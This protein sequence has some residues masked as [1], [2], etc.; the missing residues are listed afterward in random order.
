MSKTLAEIMVLP[1]KELF[2]F[3]REA[4]VKARQN[5]TED[6]LRLLA[7]ET[8][9]ATQQAT[10]AIEASTTPLVELPSGED[11]EEEPPQEGAPEQGPPSSGTHRKAAKFSVLF[12]EPPSARKKQKLGKGKVLPAMVPAREIEEESV[13]MHEF[14]EFRTET[15]SRLDMI[16]SILQPGQGF[17][18]V[19]ISTPLAANSSPRTSSPAS[20]PPIRLAPA[21]WLSP[22]SAHASGFGGALAHSPS[23]VLVHQELFPTGGTP[24]LSLPQPALSR[25]SGLPCSPAS[26]F[27]SQVPEFSQQGM[28]ALGSGSAPQGAVPAKTATLEGAQA[29]FSPAPTAKYQLIHV[30]KSCWTARLARSIKKDHNSKRIKE[31]KDASYSLPDDPYESC[32]GFVADWLMAVD[33]LPADAIQARIVKN[34]FLST[35]M[36]AAT[37]ADWDHVVLYIL[38]VRADMEKSSGGNPNAYPPECYSLNRSL[39]NSCKEAWNQVVETASKEEKALVLLHSPEK[40]GLMAGASSKGASAS[41]S[42]SK[43]FQGSKCSYC[44]LLNHTESVCRKKQ[45]ELGIKGKK[46]GKS[47]PSSSSSST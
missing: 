36:E 13:S 25:P 4:K 47:T 2:A 35:V 7:V 27:S 12:P 11:E 17:S 5:I 46:A 9:Y 29:F 21:G 43:R 3:L 42:P 30:A 32:H 10:P 23:G 16:L 45:R 38:M 8:F 24:E 33:S 18:P 41:S 37:F 34:R 19:A 22:K 1:R 44:G 20:Q 14:A 39:L 40:S 15:D 6:K 31:G 28:V 26:V